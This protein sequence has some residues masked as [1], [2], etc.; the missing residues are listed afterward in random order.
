MGSWAIE[1]IL[2]LPL[3]TRSLVLQLIL[4]VKRPSNCFSLNYL[5]FSS[6]MFWYFSLSRNSLL[7]TWDLDLLWK[8]LES[9]SSASLLSTW[10]W[11]MSTLDLSIY[12]LINLGLKVIPFISA[13]CF[14]FLATFIFSSLSY[15]YLKSRFTRESTSWVEIMLYFFRW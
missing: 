6:L 11:L 13:F 15:S 14:C 9:L 7:K 5:V 2:Y 3:V 1:P 12:L 10:V 4:G 8:G